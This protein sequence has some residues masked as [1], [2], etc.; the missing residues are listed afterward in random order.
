VK[1][2][3]AVV[4]SGG[5]P[6]EIE[7]LELGEL[8]ADEV[9]VAVEASGICHTDL[10]CRDQW[11][12]VPLPAVLGHEGAG[13][14]EEGGSGVTAVDPGDRVVMSYGFCGACEP[15]TRGLRSY[16]HAFAM[17]TGAGS[18]LNVFRPPAGSS[19]AVFGAGAVGLAAVMAA[20]IVGCMSFWRDGRFPVDRLIEYY[21]FD[22]IEQASRDAEHGPVIEP[23]LR[24][25]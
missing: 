5:A 2:R 8:R 6:F 23:V 7:E 20:A 24:M 16:C 9:L 1:V 4:E 22:Q 21:D 25:R 12:P 14:V 13:V 15:C 3:A 10:I 17:Q 11:L 18:V 19:I